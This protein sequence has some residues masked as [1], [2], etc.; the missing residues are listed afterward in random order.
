MERQ[1][2]VKETPRETISSDGHLSSLHVL[3]D[4]SYPVD[5]VP[6]THALACYH[7]LHQDHPFINDN[8]QR[9]KR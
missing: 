2:A 1:H 5:V 9:A 8:E 4:T 6:Q 3:I 7:L